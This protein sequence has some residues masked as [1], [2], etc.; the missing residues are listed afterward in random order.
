MPC[1][2]KFRESLVEFSV[3]QAV[4]AQVDDGYGDITSKASKKIKAAYFARA[5]D[6]LEQ[7]IPEKLQSILEWNA[8]CKSGARSKASKAFAKA[9]ASLPFDE[10]L[11]LIPSVPNMGRPV[12]NDDGSITVYAVSWLDDGRYRC[13]CPNFNGLKSAPHVSKKYC[14]CCA[15]HFR[16]HYEIMLDVRLETVEIVSSPLDSE[17]HDPCVIKFRVLD[18]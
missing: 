15:G 17:G 9:N 3:D 11:S 2:E 12:E 6:I 16:Y 13:A 8:C 5:I 10:R 1:P 14:F 4:I 18:H 7:T